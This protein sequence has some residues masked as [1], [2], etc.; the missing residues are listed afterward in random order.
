MRLLFFTSLERWHGRRWLAALQEN[1]E[2][3]VVTFR[4]PKK[5]IKGVQVHSI[6]P[7]EKVVVQK[8]PQFAESG[9]DGFLTFRIGL[10]FSRAFAEIIDKVQPDLV[11]AHQTV[12]S[13]WYAVC[14]KRKAKN[15]APLVVSAWGTDVS[16]YPSVSWWYRLMNKIVLRRATVITATG[17]HLRDQVLKLR[18]GAEVLLTPFGVDTSK[19]YPAAQTSGPN[20]VFGIAKALKPVY[21]I[22]VAIRSLAILIKSQPSA[23]LEIAGD[24]PEKSKLMALV[25]DLGIAH[26]VSWLGDV[27]IESIA[28]VM[29]GWNAYLLPSKR[30]AF[31]VAALEAQ[32][33]GL[34]IVAHRVGGIP[35]VVKEGSASIM[36]DSLEPKAFAKAMADIMSD[37]DLVQR[38]RREGPIFVSNNYEW[39]T[40]VRAMERLYTGA[41]N[42]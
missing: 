14:A 25:K 24:G 18:P 8:S 39:R 4:P 1:H 17:S 5:M 6:L 35:E 40:T 28:A 19:F 31:G 10:K 36:L 3:H 30:E 38:A 21:G 7:T 33:T 34:P 16:H 37:L 2:V 42:K 32:A 29:R 12:P 26:A 22:D 41:L 23:R 9:N 15:K 27:D 11:H 20:F 13:G